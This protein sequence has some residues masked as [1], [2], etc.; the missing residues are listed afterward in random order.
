MC[1]FYS[2]YSEPLF[3]LTQD[4][5]LGFTG[6]LLHQ[7]LLHFYPKGSMSNSNPLIM[8]IMYGTQNFIGTNGTD[9]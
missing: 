5:W 8:Q 2:S 4:E 1:S 9:D 3:C 7:S 6:P